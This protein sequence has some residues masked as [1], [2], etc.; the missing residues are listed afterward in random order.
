M[1]P[2]TKKESEVMNI[3]WKEH[4]LSVSQIQKRYSELSI[5]SIQQLIQRLMDAGFIKV[6]CI[7]YSGKKL[8][9]F[10]APNVSLPEYIEYI[11]GKETKNYKDTTFFLVEKMESKETL[12]ELE[13][14]V[15]KRKKEIEEKN[16]K[17]K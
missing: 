10:F 9:R 2:L 4:P 6:E 7:D 8:S 1:K 13:K 17:E 3:L 14:L 5:Y 11:I 16:C 12:E 15:Q